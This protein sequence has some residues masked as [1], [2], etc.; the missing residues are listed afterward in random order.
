MGIYYSDGTDQ[1]HGTNVIQTKLISGSYKR[2]SSN[3]WV[4]STAVN[5]APIYGVGQSRI[6]V[7]CRAQCTGHFWNSA[8]D[9]A[10]YNTRLYMTSPS[11]AE[12]TT[13]SHFFEYPNDRVGGGGDFSDWTNGPW[14]NRMGFYLV[15]DINN[16]QSAGSNI[17][18]RLDLCRCAS[19]A[20][21]VDT[22]MY[23][24]VEYTV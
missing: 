18:F 14:L 2:A 10:R 17:T 7:S 13:Q 21:D 6:R 19:S 12:W 4:S 9:D 22:A 15:S 1:T 23:T 24:V 5:Y 8:D 20:F 3:S 11:A 16:P